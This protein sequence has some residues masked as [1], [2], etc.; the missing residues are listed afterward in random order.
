MNEQEKDDFAALERLVY[1][2]AFLFLVTLCG[3]LIAVDKSKPDQPVRKSADL[4]G[5]ASHNTAK[6]SITSLRKYNQT[7]GMAH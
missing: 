6:D 4:S 5:Q 2:F 1:L 7:S 3:L